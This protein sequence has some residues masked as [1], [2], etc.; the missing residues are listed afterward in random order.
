MAL[1]SEYQG[2]PSLNITGVWSIHSLF[3]S[4]GRRTLEDKWIFFRTRFL[5]SAARW[6]R[7][8]ITLKDNGGPADGDRTNE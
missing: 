4:V 3:D 6:R 2:D 7:N 1:L 5:R 8:G